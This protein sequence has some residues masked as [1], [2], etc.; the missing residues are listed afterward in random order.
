[1]FLNWKLSA[2]LSLFALLIGVSAA[3]EPA[4]ER[5]WR[6]RALL[7]G[8]PMGE[9][10]FS[11]SDLP[12]GRLLKSSADFKV[13]FLF[14]TAYSY[15]HT[16]SERWNG[17]CLVEFRS[18]TV[19]NSDRTEV[20][21]NLEQGRFVVRSAIGVTPLDHCSMTFAYWNPKILSQTRLLH[22]QTGEWL[23]VEVAPIG[24]ETRLIRGKAVETEH[25]RITAA[26]TAIDLWYLP[27]GVDGEME[28]VGL[29]SSTPEGYVVT[30]DLI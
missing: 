4:P 5:E 1:M 3:A 11:L 23:S 30:Y 19:E 15:V 24:K 26:E 13:K 17:D 7:D 9:H 16:A 20:S 29:K 2:I 12:A 18:E 14:L 21:G 6:F 10:R 22:Q 27:A 28:W 25:Y 8:K